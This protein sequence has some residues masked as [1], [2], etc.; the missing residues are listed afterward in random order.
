VPPPTRYAR[1]GDVN[2]AYQVHGDGPI[3][4]LLNV[5]LISH[6][7]H[8]WE[9]PGV[10]RLFDR[11][12]EFTRVILM[13]RRGTGLSDP[14]T[15]ALPIEEELGD[16]TAVLDAAGAERAVLFG[17]TGSGPFVAHYAARHPE[18]VRALVLYAA[19]A[20][21]VADEEAPWAMTLEERQERLTRM[22]ES[23]GS[24]TNLDLMGPIASAD[25]RVRQWFG[26]LERLAA[27]PGGMKLLS[28][29]LARSDPR[30]IMGDIRVPTLV[31]HRKGDRFMDQRHSLLWAERIPGARYVELPG[32]ET[33]I[34]LG[35]TETMV[36][37]VEEFL[38]GRRRGTGSERQLLTV[39]FTDICDGTARAARLGDKRWR[40]LVAAHD[41]IVRRELERRDGREI[42][43]TGDGFLAVFAGPPSAAVRAAR[44][45][46]AATAELGVDVR[47][48]LHTGECELIADDVGGMAVHIA[49][50]VCA[51]AGPREVLASGTTYGTVVGAGIEWRFEGDR[52][53]KGVPGRW[54]IFRLEG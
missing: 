22:T 16:L 28:A 45:I 17:H 50:R 40:D 51:L 23:W 5:G 42:K 6:L 7:E 48:G 37:E 53:L 21:A 41:A 4:L 43:T 27:S 15:G 8:L 13:D 38:T 3:D 49:A 39:L 11:L 31:L 46:S 34:F 12:A 26:R 19:T 47:A 30:P 24:G 9:E 36:G 10:V 25:P 1:S 29:N 35:D 20:V 32:E 54:P 44:A 52:D 33:M 18:R 2:I 14:L